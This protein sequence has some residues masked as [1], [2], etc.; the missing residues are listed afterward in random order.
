M[1]AAIVLLLCCSVMS[2]HAQESSTLKLTKTIPLP[3][4]KGRFDHFA[5]D[6]KG[7]RLFV[8]A[9]GNDTLEIIDVTTG[10]RIRSISWL[11]KPQGVLYLPEPN[12][13]FVANGGD[14]TCKIFD[15]PTFKLLT[16]IGGLE[17]ADNVRF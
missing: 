11:H 3:D 15:G 13:I 12:L 10:K 6:A 4:V 17:D 16:S 1:K 2:G 9:L 8:A 7:Q 14:G 5:L